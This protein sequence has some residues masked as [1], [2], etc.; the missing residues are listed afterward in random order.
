[1]FKQEESSHNKYAKLEAE[2]KKLLK[3][4]GSELE[5][6]KL[7]FNERETR[8]VND[9]GIM[10]EKIT[11]LED[12]ISQKEAE[13]LSLKDTLATVNQSCDSIRADYETMINEHSST[14]NEKGNKLFC[15]SLKR[16]KSDE[17]SFRLKPK[18]TT[19]NAK[20]ANGDQLKCDFEGCDKED[21]DLTK[22]SMCNK[23]VCETYNDI[24]TA[25]LK[26]IMNKCRTIYF[27]C[28]TCDENIG[29]DNITLVQ[30]DTSDDTSDNNNL[31]TSLQKMLDKKAS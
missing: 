19:K 22:C 5:S 10:K 6:Y 28:K 7:D 12:G 18:R 3:N 16:V 15:T 27:L 8:L 1:M 26:P 9:N 4:Y 14:T 31:L 2:H 24:P 11:E 13:I 29:I 30:N 23:W 21:V 25:K 20:H 17:N